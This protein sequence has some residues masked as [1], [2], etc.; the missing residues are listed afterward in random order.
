MTVEP[1]GLAICRGAEADPSET[2]AE[3]DPPVA[4]DPP[5]SVDGATPPVDGAKVPPSP[6]SK[7]RLGENWFDTVP[8]IIG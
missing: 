3:S 7:E 2:S 1:S 5:A 8:V 4:T 6:K